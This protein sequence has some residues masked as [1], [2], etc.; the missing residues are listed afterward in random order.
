[1][2]QLL[3]GDFHRPN[4]EQLLFQ[5][6]QAFHQGVR[7]VHEYRSNFMRVVE[8]DDFQKMVSKFSLKTEVHP[9]PYNVCSL[10]DEEELPKQHKPMQDTLKTESEVICYLNKEE[11]VLIAESK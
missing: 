7:S 6:Y 11:P 9:Q 8:R 10:Q 1:M 5:K 4:H 2:K 3:K